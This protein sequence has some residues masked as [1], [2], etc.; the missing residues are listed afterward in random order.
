[1]RLVTLVTTLESIEAILSPA[2]SLVGMRNTGDHDHFNM[3]YHS[4]QGAD[5]GSRAAAATV[6]VHQTHRNITHM[7]TNNH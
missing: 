5:F 2:V 3:E 7:S 1:M 4:N 6:V